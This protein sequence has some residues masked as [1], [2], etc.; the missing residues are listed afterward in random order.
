MKKQSKIKSF[1]RFSKRVWKGKAFKKSEFGTGVF[2][3]TLKGAWERHM[4]RP[5]GHNKAPL[6]LTLEPDQPGA[7]AKEPVRIFI[8]TEPAQHRAERVLLWS[9][10]KQRDPSR[11]Y[12]V[13]LMTNLTGFDRRVWKTGFTSYRYAIPELAGFHG[14]AIY[15]DVDQIYLADP[16]LLQDLDMNGAGV[17]AVDS[18]DTSVML[19]DCGL[20]ADTWTINDIHDSLEGKIHTTMLKK[21][22]AKGLIAD[23]PGCWNSRDHEYDS[24]SSCLLHYTI[25][26]TQPWQP[27]PDKLRYRENPLAALWDDLE[28]EADQAGFAPLWKQQADRP[29][30]DMDSLFSI[31]P[32]G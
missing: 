31:A 11:R 9:V 14:R 23:L 32:S 19:L 4:E 26:H 17:L 27:F 5:P 3:K 18:R 8:G 20:L 6:K 28:A 24:N 21:V 7:A 22:R 2:D 15:N 30:S 29:Y 1:K 13:Y 10:A 16:A 25:L 12:E